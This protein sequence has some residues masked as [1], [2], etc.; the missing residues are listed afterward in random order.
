[1]LSEAPDSKDHGAIM[2]PTWVLLALGG[3]LVGPMN[4]AIR[5]VLLN[6]VAANHSLVAY[7]FKI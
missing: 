5:A 1:M 7:Y 6:N 3:P 2:G 4:L